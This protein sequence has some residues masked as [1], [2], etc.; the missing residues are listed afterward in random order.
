MNDITYDILILGG[1]IAG[2]SAAIYAA[3]A[4]RSVALLERIGL[5]GQASEIAT[6]E[7]YP[8]ISEAVSGL[9]LIDKFTHQ[10]E[11]LSV[12]IFYEEIHQISKRDGLF[13]VSSTSQEFSSRSLIYAL[14]AKHKHLGI[15]G[16]EDYS[17]KGVNYCAVCDG[18]F[19]KDKKVFVIGGGDTAITEALYLSKIAREVVVCHRRD[20]FRAQ[21]FL[22]DKLKEHPNV[23]FRMN[24]TVQEIKG[25]GQRVT[26]VMLCVPSSPDK[27][28]LKK[29]EEYTDGV[30]VSVGIIPQT[31]LLDP[32]LLDAN[33]FVV[34]DSSM[35][36]KVPGLYAA[37][38]VRVSPF[39][40][41][42][43]AS[44]DGA[45][46]AHSADTYV[47]TLG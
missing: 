14:G 39:R 34:V 45:I 5:G 18:S 15:P 23:S 46:A 41:L 47:S 9:D 30:F 33:G 36:T 26:G 25:N 2:M 31:Y 16:E 1:G 17:G 8:G 12:P 28:F 44:S 32:S 20:S 3:R 42:I 6:V 43:T 10:L 37:G 13:R 24:T 22:V 11:E 7:N 40:Q 4:G 29:T 21:K 19:Y 35:G 38:D 27:S